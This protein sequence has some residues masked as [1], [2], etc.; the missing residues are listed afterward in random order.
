MRV[1]VTGG[2]GFVGR[3]LVI[4]LRSRGDEAVVVSRR[5]RPGEVGWDAIEREIERADAVVHLAGEP[6]A[7]GR[8]TK[9]RLQRIRASRVEPTQAIARAIERSA[10]KPRVLVSASAVG[11]YGMRD[12]DK[13]LDESAPPADDVLASIVVEWEKA[14]G[15]AREAGVRVVHPRIGIVLGRDGG[16][17]ARMAV[18]FRWFVGGPLGNGRQWISWIHLVD[19]VRAL[20]FAIDCDGTFPGSTGPPPAKVPSAVLAGPV[21]VV[22]PEPVTMQTLAQSIARALHRPAALRVPPFALELALGRGL[23]QALLTGQ[24]AVPRKLNAAGFAFRFPGIQEACA[25]LLQVPLG[26]LA[27]QGPRP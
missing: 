4:A 12:D 9:E 17:L 14:A 26:R 5:P 27:A 16:A 1:L 18:P 20:L 10:H 7:D 25:D 24:R 13:E 23:A 8:W 6:I 22:A 19:A 3:P 11:I 21:N 15:A 2:T